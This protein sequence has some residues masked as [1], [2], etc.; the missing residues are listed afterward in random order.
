MSLGETKMISLTEFAWCVI[1]RRDV[2]CVSGSRRR[3]NPFRR[4]RVEPARRESILFS[5]EPSARPLG[6]E[7]VRVL[8]GILWLALIL[9]VSAAAQ[10]RPPDQPASQPASAPGEARKPSKA[11]SSG[12][13]TQQYDSDLRLITGNN[14]SDVRLMGAKR[15]LEAGTKEAGDRLA[16]VLQ[17]NPADLSAQ[18][19][20]CQAIAELDRT[21][22]SLA[23]PL[24]ALVGDA[25]P[26][27]AEAL[28]EALRRFD[29]G[30]VVQRLHTIAG[31]VAVAIDKREAA[32]RILGQMSENQAA[33]AALV[34]LTDIPAGGV[35]HAAFAALEQATGVAHADA[36]SAQGWWETHKSASPEDWLRFIGDYRAARNRDLRD[37]T[38]M[39]ARRLVASYREGYIHTAEADRPKKL[40]GFLKDELGEV[41]ALGLDSVDALIT[42]RKEVSQ[43]IKQRLGEMIADPDAALRQKVAAIVG[44]LRLM[45]AVPKL[46]RQL[47]A[48][49]DYRAR[50]AQVNAIGRLD[51]MDA[52]PALQERLA[53]EVPAVVGEAAAALAAISR[54][55][56][57]QPQTVDAIGA[58]LLARFETM[59]PEDVE[60]REKFLEAMMRVGTEKLRAVFK[61]EIAPDRPVRIR[62]IAVA[63]LGA[64]GDAAAAGEVRP[65]VTA[66][67]P[68]IRQAAVQA[69]GQC[70]RGRS[71]LDL[72]A[73]RMDSGSE[74]DPAVR[75]RAWESYL[76][77]A[78]RSPRAEWLTLSDA[79]DRPNDPV[80]QRRRLD[81]LKAITGSPQKFKQLPVES[82]IGALDRLG[83]AQTEL[84]DYVAAASSFEQAIGLLPE[85]RGERFVSLAA[86]L[87]SAL[88]RGRQDHAAA[89]RMVDF[90]KIV[91]SDD[92]PDAAAPLWQAV[93][94]EV[95]QRTAAADDAAEF[96]DILRLL[97]LLSRPAAEFPA[98]F[99]SP[100]RAARQDVL[101]QRETT[102]NRLLDDLAADPPVEPR[103]LAFGRHLVLPKIHARL[104]ELTA[105][106]PPTASAPAGVEERLIKL[107]KQL[108]DQWPGY[109]AES[110]AEDR[111]KALEALEVLCSSAPEEALP[112]ETYQ[113]TSS[114]TS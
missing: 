92:S 30:N 63:A 14:E 65:F 109:T 104:M 78:L 98:K 108:A 79:F 111:A 107:A 80:A 34:A 26:G 38:K 96:T 32:V 1:R 64:Y 54:R 33:V 42:D 87:V 57:D 89:E 114:P 58:A 3:R 36:A 53:D 48:E 113:P 99:A 18:I 82:Q 45:E 31:D 7:R 49:Q 110:S 77:V 28:A 37:R 97:E 17:A 61:A 25:R 35:R 69:L 62:R 39:L 72:L 47:A 16:S 103:L 52:I 22:P 74:T 85:R 55:A 51:G 15:L 71:D 6:F 40:L 27:L 100:L 84:G 5:Q 43:D 81:L 24:L 46:V 83:R 66:P 12:A 8:V 68:E 10:G 93:M 19:A 106:E 102:V 112:L 50:A 13:G 44:D 70:G 56:P 91:K 20:V 60:L 21:V 59:G 73:A 88:L 2:L 4:A 11:P 29:D 95:R 41:R 76:Q 101:A 67:E 94:D 9:S 105:A 75:E 90:S 23:E 86:P